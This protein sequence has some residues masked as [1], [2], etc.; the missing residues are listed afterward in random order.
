MIKVIRAKYNHGIFEPLE[1]LDIKDGIEVNLIIE[2][3]SDDISDEEKLDR[4]LSSAGSWKDYI[5]ED[6]LDEIYN[7][8]KRIYRPEAII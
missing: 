8:R 4:F 1:R 7:Q 2:T 6:F 5:D 3:K